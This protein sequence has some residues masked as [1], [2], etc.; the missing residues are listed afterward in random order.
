[1]INFS[2]LTG[3]VTLSHY[4]SLRVMK[5]A[6][7]YFLSFLQEF[8]QSLTNP[9]GKWLIYDTEPSQTMVYDAGL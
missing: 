3:F 1:M 2:I 6:E 4:Y 5:F 7:I 9:F 8:K